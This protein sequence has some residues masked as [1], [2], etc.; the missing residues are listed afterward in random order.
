MSV[1]IFDRLIEKGI[2]REGGSIKKCLDE[3]FEDIV[4]SDELRKLLLIE[5]SDNYE[6]YSDSE[7]NQ[8]LFR[9]FKHICIGG[10]VCQYEDNLQPYVDVTRSIYKDLI[11][12]LPFL[13]NIL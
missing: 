7:R 1:E 4:V 6:I 9:L 10:Q 2:V 11:R 3:Y 8:F 5:E 13:E 12:L